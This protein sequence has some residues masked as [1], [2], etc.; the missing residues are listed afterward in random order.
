MIEPVRYPLPLSAITE[1]VMVE[2]LMLQC[3]T[4]Y[5]IDDLK[6]AYLWLGSIEALKIVA[7]TATKMNLCVVS[8]AVK[9]R[10]LV[11]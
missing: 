9:W 2:L 4:R 11:K 10:R 3:T 7:D 1:S 8:T 5:C 6:R